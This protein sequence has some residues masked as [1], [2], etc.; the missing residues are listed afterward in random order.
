MKV[1]VAS[2]YLRP[3]FVL[4]HEFASSWI[5]AAIPKVLYLFV[6]I[7]ACRSPRRMS[8][9]PPRLV[10]KEVIL[11]VARISVLRRDLQAAA[12]ASHGCGRGFHSRNLGA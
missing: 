8:D 9:P 3:L 10:S 2:L 6:R 4:R 11:V 5:E 7:Y 1:Y 12:P